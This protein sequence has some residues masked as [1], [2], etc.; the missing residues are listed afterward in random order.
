MRTLLVAA[1]L[2]F[3]LSS[4]SSGVGGTGGGSTTGTDNS[5]LY[6]IFFRGEIPPKM[7]W[8][9]LRRLD[10]L[11]FENHEVKLGE[12]KTT[13]FDVCVAGNIVRSK[14]KMR[15]M[16]HLADEIDHLAFSQL[17]RISRNTDR[18]YYH[19]PLE[20]VLPIE[21]EIDIYNSSDPF[22]VDLSVEKTHMWISTKKY[23]ISKCK[24]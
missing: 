5:D 17:D 15:K 3:S 11:K 19:A 9:S 22:G 7:S 20:E 2:I 14:M 10:L 24:K 18:A 21:R 13:V 23:R 6:K 12:F 8:L 4:L 1:C 16:K